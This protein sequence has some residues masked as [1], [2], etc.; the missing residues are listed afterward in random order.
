MIAMVIPLYKSEN[1]ELFTN[2]KPISI[3]Q[4]QPKILERLMY[5]WIHN[6][7]AYYKKQ[8]GFK[9]NYSTNMVLIDLVY[10]LSSNID[11]KKHN[12]GI[13]RDLSKAS[14]T[15][16]HN[17]SINK[18]QCYGITIRGIACDWFKRYLDY[19]IQCFI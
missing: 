7:L 10:K 5:N 12:I 13:F 14:D 4:C 18:L 1:T 19:R 16:D 2:Y 17:I 9:E 3:L 6:F 8:Y 11:T 15:I